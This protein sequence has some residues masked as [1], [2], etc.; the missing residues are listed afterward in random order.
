MT[1]AVAIKLTWCI[2]CGDP[3]TVWPA[4]HPHHR[5]GAD[6]CGPCVSIDI[7]RDK[8]HSRRAES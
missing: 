3:T 2:W 7:A 4:D 5:E 8:A 6:E 1:A